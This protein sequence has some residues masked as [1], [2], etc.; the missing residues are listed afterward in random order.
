MTIKL[1]SLPPLPPHLTQ[2]TGKSLLLNLANRY[3]KTGGTFPLPPQ[4]EKND[5]A[6]RNDA[7][8]LN[9]SYRD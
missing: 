6:P 3:L 1:P 5:P 8:S 9:A 7:P 4:N 2:N